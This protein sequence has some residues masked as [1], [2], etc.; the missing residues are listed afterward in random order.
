MKNV[1]FLKYI[2]D[3]LKL[4]SFPFFLLLLFDIANQTFRR[5]H[6]NKKINFIVHCLV[7]FK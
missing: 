6:I 1:V 3:K 5:A 7:L 2:F 4:K